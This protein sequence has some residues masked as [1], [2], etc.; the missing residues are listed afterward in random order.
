MRCN[1]W[2]ERKNK[3]KNILIGKDHGYEQGKRNI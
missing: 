1:G 2:N 3:W